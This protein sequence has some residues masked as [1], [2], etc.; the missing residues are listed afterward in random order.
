M[1]RYA[2]RF[3]SKK[4]DDISKITELNSDFRGWTPFS[5]VVELAGDLISTAVKMGEGWLL[6]AEMMELAESGCK[7][8]VCTQPFG[9]LPNH[10]CG[11]GMMKPI[12]ELKPDVNIVA[13]DYDAGASKVNQEN[14]IKLML[15][16]AEKNKRNENSIKANTPSVK[17]KNAEL[18]K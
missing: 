16:N 3:L 1:S 12:K 6:T 4:R 15:A 14:R 7:N 9:C 13:I 17:A 18:S 8:I 10:I 2:F 11:K 5:K